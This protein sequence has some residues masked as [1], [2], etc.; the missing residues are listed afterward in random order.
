MDC[1]YS[2][3]RTA[4]WVQLGCLPTAYLQLF[5][6]KDANWKHLRVAYMYGL[7]VGLSAGKS[8]CG[9]LASEGIV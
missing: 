5:C 1:V 8:A 7:Q 4:A 6:H 2:T 9:C 3:A